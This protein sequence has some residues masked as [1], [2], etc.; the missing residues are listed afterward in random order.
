MKSLQRSRIAEHALSAGFTQ[1]AT[2]DK[3]LLKEE[4]FVSP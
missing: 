1:V 4:R 3:K 2:F